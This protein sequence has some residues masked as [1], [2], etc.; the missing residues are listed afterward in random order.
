MKGFKINIYW[1]IGILFVLRLYGITYP[2]LEVNHHW[3][4]VTGLMVA[5]NFLEEDNN[6]LYPR[7]DEV[8]IGGMVSS[9]VIGME[10]PF[11]NYLM[12]LLSL[13]AGYE[14]W[15]GRLLNLIV[16]SI[17]LLYFFKLIRAH[18]D[19][20]IALWATATLGFSVWFAFG[21]KAMPDTASVSFAFIALWNAHQ[22]L[23]EGKWTSLIAY[24]LFSTLAIL[25][26]IPSAIFLAFVP[27]ML[28]QNGFSYPNKLRV[29]AASALPL[30]MAYWWYYI[31]NPQIAAESGMWY[32]SGGSVADG[33]KLFIQEF[34]L[35]VSYFYFSTL[36]SYVL[37]A[38]FLLGIYAIVKTKDR[39][40]QA[41]LITG[42][43]LFLLYA[44]ISG[45]HFVY[46]HYYMIFLAPVWA[47]I[48]ALSLRAKLFPKI[49]MGL[50]VIGM[51]EAYFNQLHD[52][53]IHEYNWRKAELEN[54]FDQFSDR[55]DLIVVN[56]EG[57]PQELY[58]SHRKGWTCKNEEIADKRYMN[59]VIMAGAK[60]LLINTRKGDGALDY[61]IVYQDD[62]YLIYSLVREN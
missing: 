11:M 47:L 62:I 59:E 39:K 23:K 21:R 48:V 18:W 33:A 14:H 32:N 4:Q 50:M 54:I 42:L 60:Y 61:P 35:V 10:F 1:V 37:L 17:G 57:N 27:L 34:S 25:V 43:L 2:P 20:R 26:K 41:V 28:W 44:F 52:F 6:I 8:G 31:W 9:G 16:T 55:F 7:V 19:E 3:R 12:Y 58:M 30:I 51:I 36:M 40:A 29:F 53:R 15:Y 24:S 22:H 13:V 56:G 46:Q 49:V 45:R 5:R 38:I